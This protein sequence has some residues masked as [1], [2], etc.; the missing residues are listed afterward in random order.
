[1][2]WYV[3]L[4]LVSCSAWSDWLADLFL[5]SVSLREHS[6]STP[7]QQC[8]DIPVMIQQMPAE[9]HLCEWSHS[10][11]SWMRLL[12]T[13]ITLLLKCGW[14]PEVWMSHVMP[15]S[16]EGYCGRQA[17]DANGLPLCYRLSAVCIAGGLCVTI[18]FNQMWLYSKH[19][20]RLLMINTWAF[21][22]WHGAF[23]L[24]W[25]AEVCSCHFAYSL[26]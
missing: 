9:C 17:E 14:L 5:T 21:D 8:R 23:I 1:M 10:S 24:W 15:L 16:V 3:R 20:N 12:T 18:L 19:S 7:L 25:I 13:H 11:S 22:T 6:S 26:V 2:M 4:P